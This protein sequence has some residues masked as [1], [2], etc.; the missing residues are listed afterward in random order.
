MPAA[1]PLVLASPLRLPA[2]G[3]RVF[4]APLRLLEVDVRRH[5]GVGDGAFDNTNVFRGCAELC[6]MHVG[7]NGARSCDVV[8]PPGVFVTGAFN[9][10]SRVRLLLKKGAVVKAVP[11]SWETWRFHWPPVRQ[12]NGYARSRDACCVPWRY[13]LFDR[14]WHHSP[15]IGG[16]NVTDVGISGQGVID[17]NGLEW[18]VSSRRLVDERSL[19]IGGAGSCARGSRARRS[20]S[21]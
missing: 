4:G 9:L 3:P 11:F 8:V 16:Y 18:C 2:P 7:A 20:S 19:S 10:T 1:V 6:E 21:D 13:P 15:L 17:G 5:G 12:S 14:Q